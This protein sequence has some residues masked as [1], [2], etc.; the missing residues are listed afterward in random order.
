M[1]QPDRPQMT[2]LFCV[3]EM[4]FSWELIKGIIQ[5][6]A[7]NISYLNLRK[8]LI[9]SDLVKCFTAILTKTERLS[10]YPIY[11]YYLFS[12]ILRIK[13]MSKRTFFVSMQ[14]LYVMCEDR[15]SM[16]GI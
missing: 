11:H 1:V 16:F 9:S 10:H 15:A 2:T 13:A 3:E 14:R 7:H 6:H 8:L 12:Q 5:T 4:C